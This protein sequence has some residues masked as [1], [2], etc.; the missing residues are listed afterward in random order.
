M[1]FNNRCRIILLKKKFFQC[2]QQLQ[3]RRTLEAIDYRPLWRAD[4]FALFEKNDLDRHAD[5]NRG[6]AR[7]K[8]TKRS[9]MARN[10]RYGRKLP[11]VTVICAFF[12]FSPL[13]FS[14][15][16]RHDQVVQLCNSCAIITDVS[17]IDRFRRYRAYQGM[18]MKKKK[19]RKRSVPDFDPS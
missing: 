12:F 14:P 4:V 5:G 10:T 1:I 6:C 3:N 2:W 11:G 9:L 8:K 7:G 15:P 19:K 17:A 13:P 16:Y 18:K